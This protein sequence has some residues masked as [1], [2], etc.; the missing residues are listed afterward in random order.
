MKKI[1][2][3]LIGIILLGS[4]LHAARFEVVKTIDDLNVKILMDGEHPAVGENVFNIFLSD[5][6]GN[7]EAD[8]KIRITYSM[9][10]MKGMEPMSYVTRAKN[11]GEGY[12]A[13]LDL[14]MPGNWDIGLN[15]KRD[16]KPKVRTKF[17]LSVQ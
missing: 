7:T 12:R 1:I 8:A 11:S 17:K 6:E 5:S 10:V 2:L 14:A 16:G 9:P 3:F 15:I 4:T 13:K